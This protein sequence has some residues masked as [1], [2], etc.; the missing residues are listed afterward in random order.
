MAL[1]GRDE[2]QA[3]IGALLDGARSGHS[4]VLV[5]RGGPGIGK[6]ALLDDAAGR[7]DGLRVL[8][9][10]GAEAEA[11]LPF[12]GLHQLLAP[13][14]SGAAALPPAQAGALRRAL[15]LATGPEPEPL[16]LGAAALGLLAEAAPLVALVDDW[17]WLDPAS[18]AALGFAGR[19]LRAE[20]VALV[21]AVRDDAPPTGLP[22]RDLAPLPPG[23]AAALL[24]G[25]AP[26]AQRALIGIAAG[27][28]L[29]L[30]ELPAALSP[31]QRA[32]RAPI[33]APL[34]VAGQLEAL[35]AG[36]IAALDEAARALLVLAAADGTGDPA[37]VLRAAGRT[38][39]PAALDALRIDGVLGLAGDRLAWRHPLARSAVLRSAPAGELRLAHAG[40]AAVAEPDRAAW[41]RASAAV[42]PDPEAAAALAAA[43]ER[44]RGRA[45]HAAAAAALARAAELTPDPG[46]RTARRIAA[47]AAAWNAGHGERALALL[48]AAG[49][50]ATPADRAEAA[51]IRGAIELNAGSPERAHRLL[52]EAVHALLPDDPA[53]AMRLGVSAMEAASLAGLPPALPLPAAALD[54]AADGA[55]G[56]LRTFAR[57]ILAGFGGDPA[58][59]AAALGEVVRTAA[60]LEDAQLVL[61]A[62]AAA[63]FIGDE[64][65]A[66]ALHERA[67][68]LARAGGDAAVLP[69]ALTFLATAH[70]WSGRPA[71]AEAEAE[72]AGRLAREAGQD[73]L[74]LQVDTVLAG[75]A[76]LRG[77]AQECRDLAEG[78]RAAARERGLVLTEGTATIAL[79]E[80]DLAAGAPAAAYERLDALAHGAGAHP[81]HRHS[82]VPTLVEAA[83]RAG[84]PEDG[85]AAAEAFAAWA[86]ATGSG[87]ALP[88][89]ARSLGLVAADPAEGDARLA[90]ALRLHDRHRR[91][92]D[93]A[94]TELLIGERLRRARRKA[95]ARGPLRAALETFEA[96]GA[97]P[98]AARA[99][100]ELRAAGERA[101]V[102]AGRPLDRLTPQELQVA[103]LVARGDSNRDAAA[104]LFLSPRTVE[105]HLHKVFR[106]LGVH[107]RAELAAALATPRS[108][109]AD[110][111]NHG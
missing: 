92:L 38:D 65:A 72:E 26:A 86:E 39:G 93:R 2:E 22:E 16:L 14:L 77:R 30:V 75:V 107:A 36:R 27:N 88:L 94:R 101:P 45:G 9:A 69:F 95:E 89:A 17:Q 78:A 10:T 5:L 104:A 47:A 73:N 70:L 76:A 52:A 80:L 18:V 67:A 13:V 66:V 51:R 62:G 57:G 29:A 58:G 12:A 109:G 106:K 108:P 64:D 96:A 53:R 3:A 6:T 98:W 56:F 46:V 87:W 63:F 100:D 25:L 31:G 85:R 74:A 54:A 97:E 20:G 21:G 37:L 59:A 82:V 35:F 44:A 4:G 68:T 1:H 32:G 48:D 111:A 60:A 71:V 50:P 83:A 105:Y 23:A 40:L 61:W 7:A 103:R 8:R 11:D 55:T 49:P 33:E 19:R 24:D 34:P 81:A 91:P 15:G 42:G 99:R 43:G 110:R 28:P 84:R 79:A 102:R 41:H 90:E